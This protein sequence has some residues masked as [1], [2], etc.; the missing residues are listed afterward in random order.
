MVRFNRMMNIYPAVRF[1]AAAATIACVYFMPGAAAGDTVHLKKGGRIVGVITGESEQ[2]IE[3]KSNMGTIVLSKGAIARI[4]KADAEANLALENQWKQEREQEVAKLKEAKQAEEEQRAK[5]MVKYMGTWMPAEK[6]YEMEKGV[7]KDKEEWER[8]AEQ[9]RK[10]LQ[11][12]ERR[13]TDLETRLEQRQRDMDYREQQL[14][15]R[16]QNLLLQQQN[17]QRQADQFSR[18]KQQ[19]PTKYFAVPRI[20]VFPPPSE[21]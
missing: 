9:Q 15:L 17:L 16:E 1:L 7:A 6:V 5:G 11:D 13:L 18:E 14:G 2:S 21:E 12:M 4:E 20:D 10:E 3:I 19:R 8:N